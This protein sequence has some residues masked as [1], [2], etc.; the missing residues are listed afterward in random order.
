[1]RGVSGAEMKLNLKLT[2][3]NISLRLDCVKIKKC[4]CIYCH[5]SQIMVYVARQRVRIFILYTPSTG[6]CL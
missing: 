4:I 2:H 3:N 5:K 1:M 6:W